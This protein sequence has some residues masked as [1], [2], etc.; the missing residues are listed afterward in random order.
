MET[1]DTAAMMERI[2]RIHALVK[3][4]DPG[5][6]APEDIAQEYKAAYGEEISEEEATLIVDHLA[7]LYAHPLKIRKIEA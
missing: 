1:E 6:F 7:D 2:S 3:E 4:Y 5:K